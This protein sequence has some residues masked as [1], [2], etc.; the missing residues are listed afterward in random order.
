MR[1]GVGTTTSAE[2]STFID[3]STG[4]TV[5]QLTSATS[6]SYPLYYFIPSLTADNRFLVF[7]SER[8]EGRVNLHRL[9]LHDGSIT[10]LTDGYTVDAG[11]AIWCEWHL[12]GIYNHLSALD[13]DSGDVYYVQD[14]SLLCVNAYTLDDRLVLKLPPG[15]MPIGQN[16]FSPDGKL[17]AFI[18]ANAERF[19]AQLRERELLARTINPWPFHQAFRNDVGPVTL[20]VV[21]TRSGKSRDVITTDCHFHHVLFTDNTTLLLNH[22]KGC[23]G[24]WIVRVDGTGIRLLRPADAL[25]AHGVA[26]VHQVVT[27]SGIFYEARRSH[28]ETT[29]SNYLGHYD[30]QTNT[31][32]E[33]PL[34]LGGYVHTG[35]DPAGHFLFVEHEEKT[36]DLLSV[37]FPLDP[38]RFRLNPLRRLR[39]SS[40]GGQRSHAHPF[41]STDRNWLY[42]TDGSDNGFN[43][44]YRINVGNISDIDEY[45]FARSNE[46]RK[47]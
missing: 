22:P 26:V 2:W 13:S 31:F 21:D 11:W 23:D 28:P 41:L 43:Q 35:F 40:P 27:A 10:Q 38:T 33:T 7:H 8:T 25:G 37:H 36:H 6:H 42:F 24:M 17:F 14:D 15:Q 12:A 4:R 34:G 20:S 44:I 47:E 18:H 1:K 3:P 5:Q 32:E 46:N 30:L 16:A 39:P 19:K 29:T 45:S 9:D